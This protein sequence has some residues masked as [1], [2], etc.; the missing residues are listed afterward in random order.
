MLGGILA[1]DLSG[2]CGFAHGHAGS[3][4]LPAFGTWHLPP[5]AWLGPKFVAYEN[6]LIAALEGLQPKLVLMEA[7]L[8]ASR[9]GSTNVAR[10]Q[11]GLAAI[12]EAECCRARVVLREQ[13]AHMVRKAVL[14]RGA[15]GGSEPAKAAV[16]AWCRAQGYCVTD[17]HQAD[18]LVLF[19]FACMAQN[20]NVAK[21]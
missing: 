10:Q 7:P 3:N 15:F 12:T 19:R 8:P 1:L 5:G 17:D 9:Q 14:G 13:P 20:R 4:E 18:A 16:I 6:E 21:G 11:F 2:S